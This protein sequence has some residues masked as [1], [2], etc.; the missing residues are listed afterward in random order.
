MLR[1]TDQLRHKALVFTRSEADCSKPLHFSTRSKEKVSKAS[2][3]H[4]GVRVGGKL[5]EQNE[6]DFSEIPPLPRQPLVFALASSSLA[7]LS[8]CSKIE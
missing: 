1:A 6:N 8:V 7:I 2:V 5:Y 4:E 3:D